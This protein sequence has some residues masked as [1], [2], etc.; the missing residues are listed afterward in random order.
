MFRFALYLV[1]LVAAIWI[2]LFVFDW[3]QKLRKSK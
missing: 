1:E 3:V 2:V